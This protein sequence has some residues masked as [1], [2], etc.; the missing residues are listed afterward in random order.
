MIQNDNKIDSPLGEG[1]RYAAQTVCVGFHSF[2][3]EARHH[4]EPLLTV[5]PRIGNQR[6]AG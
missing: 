2:P 4:E 5:I 3:G 1:S 6:A